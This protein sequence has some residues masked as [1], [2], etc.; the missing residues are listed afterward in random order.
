MCTFKIEY[1]LVYGFCAV[2]TNRHV[3]IIIDLTLDDVC[4]DC[5]PNTICLEKPQNRN[6]EEMNN[7]NN[8][9]KK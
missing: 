4:Q 9:M 5:P 2:L 8:L 1:L 7:V 6:R 3:T